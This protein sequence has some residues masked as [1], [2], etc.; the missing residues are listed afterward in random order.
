[1][2][3]IVDGVTYNTDTS[4]L[5]ASQ[6]WK[7]QE[8]EDVTG[9]LYQTQAGAFFELRNWTEQVWVERLGETE[10]RERTVL[11]PLRADD[12]RKWM[13]E[14]DVEVHANVFDD[15]PEAKGDDEPGSSTIFIRMAPSLKRAVEQAAAA[16]K[17][18][19][20]A[21]MIQRAEAGLPTPS[22]KPAKKTQRK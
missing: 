5:L 10:P 20:N 17:L 16:A 11:V 15:P 13:L 1:M 7:S 3:R 9:N 2:K 4:R 14:G 21:W 6:N 19:V 22:K 8:G 18:S 12:A